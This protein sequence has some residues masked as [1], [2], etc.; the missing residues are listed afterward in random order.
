MVNLSTKVR[1]QFTER[2]ARL[3]DDALQ[4]HPKVAAFKDGVQKSSSRGNDRAVENR[5]KY[6][7]NDF[8]TTVITALLD[9]RRR[10]NLAHSPAVVYFCG[11]WFGSSLDAICV[12]SQPKRSG[13]HRR[14]G[15][16]NHCHTEPGQP[17]LPPHAGEALQ[18]PNH[19]IWRF[20]PKFRFTSL[21]AFCAQVGDG[22][23]GK[24]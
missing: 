18:P 9:V 11:W 23:P 17:L 13:E 22:E 21:Y 7:N 8:R 16:R 6:W 5:L 14:P 24:E 20:I 15:W 10:G 1:E 2:I 4:N 12:F 19:L 3:S